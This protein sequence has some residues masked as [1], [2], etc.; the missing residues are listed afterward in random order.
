MTRPPDPGEALGAMAVAL[1]PYLIPLIVEALGGAPKAALVDVAAAVPARKRTLY[2]ACRRGEIAG[3]SRVGRRWLAPR[4]SLDAWLASRGPR[5][6]PAL[7]EADELES[8]R[9]RLASGRKRGR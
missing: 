1:A 5:L 2:A 8:V 9:Q 3:A 4:A 6:V 7:E